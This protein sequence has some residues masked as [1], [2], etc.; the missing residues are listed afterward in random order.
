[1][2][3]T[4]PAADPAATQEMVTAAH[5]KPDRV[6]ALLAQNP[7]EIKGTEDIFDFYAHNVKAIVEA[8]K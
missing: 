5:S 3:P 8:L 7:G 4:F 2:P 1:M 6:R